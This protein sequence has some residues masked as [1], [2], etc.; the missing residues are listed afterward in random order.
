VLN[1]LKIIIMISIAV[2]VIALIV[3]AI[4]WGYKANL[5]TLGTE[6]AKVNDWQKAFSCF[7]ELYKH[8]RNFQD[9]AIR[10]SDAARNAIRYQPKEITMENEIKILRWL[11]YSGDLEI[12]ADALDNSTVY[13]PAGDFIMGDENGDTDERPQRIIHL[14]AF[15][16]D[17]YEV[18][19]I[20]YQRFV[21]HNRW[22]TPRYW[23]GTDY[24]SGQVDYPVAGV[25]WEDA[26]AYC[27][28][29]GKK[30]PTEVEWEKACRG[31]NGN[32]FPWG[33]QWDSERA[34]TGINQADQ[35]PESYEDGWAL[36]PTPAT[37]SQMLGLRP[38]GSYLDGAS[39]YGVLD[40]TG[41]V[42]EWIADWYNPNFY[43]SMSVENPISV[44]PP[45]NHSVR[46]MGWYDRAGQ[47][48]WG[49]H[50]SRCSS[51]NASHSY[52]TP[53]IGFRCA[54]QTP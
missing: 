28:W 2:T 52:D 24:P 21:L 23:S 47:E 36:L 25:G 3:V 49:E 11:V 17:R 20:Q 10:L 51:R 1:I 38:V 4:Q 29:V 14:D 43:A 15:E 33:D 30:L 26:N 35:W 12:L 31:P 39:S 27:A 37:S 53:R 46:G 41:N 8:D 6:A 18:T 45:W 42:S 34:N 5:Y 19:N 48:S 9:V 54:R 50:E 32:I 22:R 16:I 7:Y 40:L 44:E 13:I